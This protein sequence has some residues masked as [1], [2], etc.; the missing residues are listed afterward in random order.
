M[1]QALAL[2]GLGGHHHQLAL[3]VRACP[4]RRR[5]CC[6]P[7]FEFFFTTVNVTQSYPFYHKVLKTINCTRRSETTRETFLT[8]VV[9]DSLAIWYEGA[10]DR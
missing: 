10:I 8:R 1:V 3:V 6:F 5:P 2:L 4:R 7:A 9:R